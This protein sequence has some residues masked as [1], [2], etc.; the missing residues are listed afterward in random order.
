MTVH[1]QDPI[2]HARYIEGFNN[3][4]KLADA[5]Q[6]DVITALKNLH[7]CSQAVIVKLESNPIIMDWMKENLPAGWPMF[8]ECTSYASDVLAKAEGRP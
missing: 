1:G 6:A 4:L 7:S 2:T 3:A 8:E 5:S